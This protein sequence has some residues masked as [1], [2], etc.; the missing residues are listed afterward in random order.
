MATDYIDLPTMKSYLGITNSSNDTLIATAITSASRAVDRYCQRRFW[1]DPTPVARTFE[2][3]Y[4]IEITLPTGNDIGSTDGFGVVT[5]PAG[6][7]LF[8]GP[9]A[10]QWNFPGDIQLLPTNAPTDPPEPKPWTGMRAVGTK[11]FPWLVNTWLTHLDR[12]QITARWG[13][14]E[15]PADVVSATLMKAARLYHRKDSPQGIAGY[16][17]FGPV[18]LSKT[19]DGD[20]CDMLDGYRAMPVM[21]A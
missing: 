14:P 2:P 4:L 8:T 6:N 21:V 17:E 13:W 19:Q 18:R 11:T 1:L 15:I 12:I 7:G 20:V 10:I 5:D 16:G 9:T 3:T